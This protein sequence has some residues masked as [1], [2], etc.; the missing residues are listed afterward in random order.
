LE[1]QLRARLAT[2]RK[3][4]KIV[5]AQVAVVE[6]EKLICDIA[7]GCLSSID[8]RPV[9][10]ETRFPVLGTAAGLASIALIRTLRR[11]HQQFFSNPDA[12]KKALHVPVCSMWPQVSNGDCSITLTQLLSHRA[13]VQN[14]YP[15]S[16]GPRTLDDI[17]GVTRHFE[18]IAQLEAQEARYAYLLQAFLLLKLGDAVTGK[19]SLLHWLGSEL[20]DLGLDVAAPMG[21]GGEA[22]VCRDL[23][24]LARVS[25]AEVSQGDTRRKTRDEEARRGDTATTEETKTVNG[26]ASV[27]RTLLEAVAHDPLTFDP[28]QANTGSGGCFRAGLSLG[29]SARGLATMLSSKELHKD[30]EAL[31]ALKVAEQDPTAVGWLLTGGACTWTAGGLQVFDL[32]GGLFTRQRGFG[33]ACG[34]GPCVVHFPGLG[35]GGVTVAV[36]LNDVL[37]G[38]EVAAELFSEVLRN[39]GYTPEWP[40]MPMRVIVDAMRL[41]DSP[42]A[43]PLMKSL[44]GLG[45]L[46]LLRDGF[47]TPTAIA[48][49]SNTMVERWGSCCSSLGRPDAEKPSSVIKIV[50]QRLGQLCSTLCCSSTGPRNTLIT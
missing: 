48:A 10:S 38:R 23:P 7:D 25:M 41:K 8:A 30:F 15:A 26:N 9:Q 42:E 46:K 39:Y 29:A 5:G 33:V 24:Q 1:Q 40:E 19:D 17:T 6:D 50:L 22:T 12:Q 37:R 3:A 47:K 32:R 13:G 28:L 43:E 14:L 31:E 16:F 11:K 36:M 45:G 2:L 34:L 49:P 44:G 27:T 20:A 35:R 21:K 18:E 4:G